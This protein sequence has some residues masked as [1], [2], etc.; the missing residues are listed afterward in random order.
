M[1][2]ANLQC[3]I[4]IAALACPCAEAVCQMGSTPTMSQ[5]IPATTMPGE[6][7][8]LPDPSG[9]FGI[10]RVG[11]EWIDA[12]RP[13]TFSIDPVSA[14][15]PHAPRALMVYLWYPTPKKVSEK[16]GIYLPGA[17]QMD[18]NSEVRSLV[19]EEFGEVWPQIVSGDL[20]S[21]AHENAPIVKSPKSLP[22]VI[23]SH[24]LGS[25]G[26]EYTSWIE[27]LVSNGYVVVAIEHTYT[28]FAVLFP[29]GKVVPHRQDPTPAGLSPEQRMQ[30]MMT[31]TGLEI[32]QGAS[33]VVFAL[34]KLS[35]LNRSGQKDFALGGKLDLT[36]VAAA[37][38]SAG[39]SYAARACQL[40]ARLRACMSLDG[41]LPPVSAFPEF[42]DKK[43]FQQPV[44]LL[45]VD[46]TGDRMPFSPEQYN[47][48]LKIKDAEL[49]LCPPGSYDV[50]LKSA[51]M[52]HGSFSDYRL[53]A[54]ARHPSETKEA[55]Y[56]LSLIESF[57]RA[58]LDKSLNHA[59]EPLLDSP[60]QSSEA[61]VEGYGQ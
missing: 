7:A 19:K 55:L 22:V 15:A 26:F 59:K 20:K 10:G 56:N 35:S 17:K 29:D 11:Y 51:G 54:A 30:R 57:S 49:K 33:D 12:S 8:K 34:N 21:H 45:E 5:N 1:K 18:A 32:A 44:L 25:S 13:D 16:S 27:D 31:S 53:L 39:G 24:G 2:K 50:L 6:I 3:F 28:A 23:F 37:G 42:P 47:D 38:H 61:R 9:P 58:F 40:D 41:A 48:F 60:S 4:A 36:R 43:K 46:H 52:Y 14:D